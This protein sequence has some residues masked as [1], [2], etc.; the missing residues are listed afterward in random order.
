MHVGEMSLIDPEAPRCATVNRHEFLQTTAAIAG[1]FVLLQSIFA[2][3]LS[4]SHFIHADPNNHW[5]VADPAGWSM[6][7]A[8]APVMARAA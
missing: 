2:S 6:Q 3:P 7:N 4:D 1:S 5:P 8:H